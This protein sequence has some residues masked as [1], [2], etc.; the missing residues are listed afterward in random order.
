MIESPNTPK[1]NADQTD[2]RQ[3]FGL[4]NYRIPKKSDVHQ[5]SSVTIPPVQIEQTNNNDKTSDVP[6]TNRRK[7]RFEPISSLSN[8]SAALLPPK[9]IQ[10]PVHTSNTP[11]SNTCS[12]SSTPSYSENNNNPVGQITTQS[13]RSKPVYHAFAGM[14][15]GQTFSPLPSYTVPPTCYPPMIPNM[16]GMPFFPAIN[17]E[18][19]PFMMPSFT[20]ALMH[21]SVVPPPPPDEPT[22]D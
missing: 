12:S 19:G 11:C 8:N 17:M 6:V 18:A 9:L 21:Y 14:N 15:C 10:I 2:K 7:S 3:K 22:K 4:L 16:Y 20:D 5:Q 1:S 13:N